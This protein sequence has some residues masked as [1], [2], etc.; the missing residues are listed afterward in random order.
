M[1]SFL[2]QLGALGRRDIL[3]YSPLNPVS[4]AA[5]RAEE[6]LNKN[7]KLN[8]LANERTARHCPGLRPGQTALFQGWPEVSRP[9]LLLVFSPYCSLWHS[10]AAGEP[11]AQLS[12][13]SK[14]QKPS[15]KAQLQF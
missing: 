8:E 12:P 11:P 9:T 14:P 13:Q 5:P 15:R 3:S 6:V 1:S 7:S 4:N 10:K 2:S